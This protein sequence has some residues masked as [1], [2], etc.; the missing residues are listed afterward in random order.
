[1][2]NPDNSEFLKIIENSLKE[3]D[4]TSQFEETGEVLSIADGVVKIFGLNKIAIG[5]MVEF[6]SGAKGVI[7]S[8]EYD[9]ASAVFF[10]L[11][12]E[13]N[14][15]DLVKRLNLPLSVKTGM[16]LLGRVVDGLGNPIDGLGEISSNNYSKVE[17]KAP[18]IIDRKSVHEPV[19]TGIKIIDSLIPIGR[20]QRELII[21]DRKTGKTAIA[22]DTILN[23]IET[24]KNLP[25]KEKLYCIYVA[26][27][28]KTSKISRIAETLRTK[29]AMEFTTIVCAPAS[30]VASMQFIA[31]Y[32]G[33]TIAEYF[34]DNG[35]HALIVYDDLT[36]HAVAYRQISLLLKRPPS[37]EAYP[38]DVFYLHSRLLERAAKMSDKKGAG[39]LTALPIIETQAN[40]VSAYIPTNVISITD[41][42]IFLESDLFLKGIRPAVNIG[43]S[44][45]RVGSAA[46]TKATKTAAGRL[47]I[48]LAQFRELEAFSQ[49]ASDMDDETKKIIQSGQK[50]TELLKQDEFSPLIMA[51]QVCILYATK[52]EYLSKIPLS[53]VKIFEQKLIHDLD[54][55]KT[56]LFSITEDKNLSDETI[57]KLIVVINNIITDM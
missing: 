37:R 4:F 48:D 14:Q 45:S 10:G 20:G 41:G 11:D 43:L 39:S 49:F 2:S 21:G 19:Q 9:T 8:I 33:C 1:M 56:I 53:K 29:G 50:L 44:V 35:M 5:E 36:K 18:G 31:P 51:K 38:G 28:A 25:E 55:E 47:K 3:K 52:D 17:V 34:R 46:Q 24:N 23:Q 15:G 42:Q 57:I 27:G 13:I 32:T 12:T 26:I 30:D 22:I 7:L 40:D 54:I 16:N 6:S